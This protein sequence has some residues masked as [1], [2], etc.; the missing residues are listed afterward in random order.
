[1]IN[2]NEETINNNEEM[3]LVSIVITSFNREKYIEDAIKTSLSQNYQNIEVIISDNCSTDSTKE[4][5][6]KYLSDPRIKYY[7]NKTNI[8]MNANFLKA[9]NELS[10]GKYITY[11]SS[12]D[13]LIN[14]N[15][16]TEAIIRIKK[17]PNIAL[18]HS[19]NMMENTFTNEKFVD[20]S[21]ISL[22]DKF[23]NK[24]YVSGDIVFQEFPKMHSISMGGTL[25]DRKKLIEIKP[26]NNEVLSGDVWIILHLLQFT[27]VSFINKQTYMARRH[28]NNATGTVTK[29]EIYIEN[30]KYID[31]PYIYALKNKKYDLK[32]LNEWHKNMYINFCSKCIINLYKINKKE[33]IKFN[34]YLQ[35]EKPVIY[36]KLKYDSKLLI[37]KFV[38]F[39]VNTAKTYEI[40]RRIISKIK[41]KLVKGYQYDNKN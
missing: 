3:P 34:Q 32:F 23:Y 38:Y 12:D 39:N 30:L 15:F 11:V 19:V 8:G 36:S 21:Y 7:V 4:I 16:I 18:V 22:K 27:N 29:A 37:S 41:D 20:S 26:F 1:M 40:T 35:K 33:Y 10:N 9:T 25:F 5:I 17:Y 28:Q 31:D 6:K 14:E 24:D 2:A 13:Y